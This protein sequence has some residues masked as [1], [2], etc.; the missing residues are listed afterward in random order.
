MVFALIVC[1]AARAQDGPDET[2]YLIQPEDILEIKV[3]PMDDLSMEIPVRPDGRISYPIYFE[4]DE[5]YK[6]ENTNEMNE[7]IDN[8][9]LFEL[10]RTPE[11]KVEG[12]TVTELTR[13]ITLRIKP[14]VSRPRVSIN[15]RNFK[16]MRAFVLG[17][18]ANPGVY[19]IRK[20]HTVLDAITEAG[21]FAEKA[22]RSEVA[23]IHAPDRLEIKYAETAEG[24]VADAEKNIVLINI[25]EV[26]GKGD[27]PDK[28]NYFLKDGDIVYVPTGKKV[29]WKKIYSVVSSLYFAF[30]IED[31]ID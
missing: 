31:L 20:G 29:D 22:K 1:H 28:D 6:L 7:I 11:I 25:A 23:L 30:S 14:F 9:E 16:R 17:A 27:Y 12:M 18:V 13:I 21:G 24:A 26:V 5:D 3:W 8:P 4:N 15:V 2:S 10:V 19:E